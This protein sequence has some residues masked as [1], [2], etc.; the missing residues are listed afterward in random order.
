MM[1]EQSVI[2]VYDRIS[3]AEVAVH[4]LEQAGFSAKQLSLVSQNLES[5]QNVHGYITAED[6]Q[7]KRGARSGAWAGGLFGLLTGAAFLWIPGFGPLLIVGRLA[8]VLL[9]SIEGALLGAAG[10]GFMGALVNC[11]VADQHVPHYEAHLTQGK[12]LVVAHGSAEEVVKARD[13][14]Q[15]TEAEMVNVHAEAMA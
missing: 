8:A 7:T 12:C 4:T 9:A 3:K 13:I 6:D 15:D 5:D 14:L 1:T 11:G 10:G 2:A